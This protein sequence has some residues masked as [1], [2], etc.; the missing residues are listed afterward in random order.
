MASKFAHDVKAPRRDAATPV[1]LSSPIRIG[2]SLFPNNS[3][4]LTMPPPL[5]LL[6]LISEWYMDEFG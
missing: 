4:Y 5:S 6:V 2:F 3:T 1:L